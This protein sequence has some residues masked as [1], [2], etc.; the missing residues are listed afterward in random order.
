MKKLFMF[1]TV[2]AMSASLSAAE[3]NIYASGLKAGDVDASNK[4]EINYLLN[5]PATAVTL[6]LIQNDAVVKEIA[7]TGEANLTKGAHAVTVDLSVADPG[8]YNWAI[9][10]AAAA[11][12]AL[13]NVLDYDKNMYNFYLPMGVAVNTN[14]ENDYFGY[15]YVTEAM[16]GAS[17]GS[18]T[19]SKATKNGIFVY[20]PSM[21]LLNK[22]YT[23]YKGGVTFGGSATTGPRRP[24]I[25]ANGYVYVADNG[26]ATAGL[27]RIDPADPSADF[28]TILK[29]EAGINSFEIVGSG[30]DMAVYTLTIN[31]DLT[32]GSIKKYAVGE[33]TNYTEEPLIYID[34]IGK[35][36]GLVNN[37]N[38][39]VS[40]GKG[41][42]WIAQNRGQV[43]YETY[44]VLLHV[45]ATGEADYKIKKG[46]NEGVLDTIPGGKMNYNTSARGAV[47]VSPDGKQLA[48]GSDRKVYV[49]D[50]TYDAVTGVPTLDRAYV[51]P[52]LR[53]ANKGANVDGLSFDYAGNLYALCATVEQLFVFAPAK[54]DNSCVTPAKKAS[55]LTVAKSATA[56]EDLTGMAPGRKG[57]FTITGQYLGESVQNL[58]AG[59]YIV[60][61]QKMIIR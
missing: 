61:G 5:A 44:P 8:T 17:D 57:V 32:T 27:W 43:I 56:L 50:I 31:S 28:V 39:I 15:T 14:P 36:L 33:K 2:A 46:E 21:E 55:M 51:T 12:E 54:A 34:S 4:V 59:M 52:S 42:F 53:D 16:N 19:M 35:Y 9:K 37:Y 1:L 13:V 47:A 10:A 18:W 30:E 41:G 7:I 48:F 49:F 60:N 23:G 26:A 22:D 58:P 29:P 11:N 24:R 45:N 38:S 6:Q 3:M 25:D 40:D 20:N